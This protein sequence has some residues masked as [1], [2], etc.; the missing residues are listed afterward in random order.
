METEEK[1]LTSSEIE[2]MLKEVEEIHKPRRTVNRNRKKRKKIRLDRIIVVILAIAAIAGVI[3][4]ASK[5]FDD[6]NRKSASEK[7]TKALSGS[8]LQDDQY[9]EITELVQNYLNAY[10]IS[11]DEKRMNKIRECVVD[12]DDIS[13]IKPREYVKN[14]SDV[15]CYT[16]EGPYD[17]T[18]IVY[19]YFQTTYVNISTSAPSIQIYYVMRKGET[20]DVYIKNKIPADVQEYID[21]VSKDADVQELY[22]DVQ[23]EMDAA[24]TKDKYLDAFLKAVESKKDQPAETSET[25][26]RNKK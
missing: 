8:P 18:Y 24:R 21:K 3:V 11:D 25:K 7:D 14:Y 15:E 17:A 23:K 16:K 22:S 2:D 13:D 20:M 12:L 9:P 4:L 26:K 5:M 6:G 1:K 10:L 19:A